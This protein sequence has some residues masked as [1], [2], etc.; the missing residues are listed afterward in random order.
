MSVLVN[1]ALGL[2]FGLGLVLS[3]MSDPAK[4][5]N[6]LDL[7]GSFDPSLAFVMGGAVLVA[8][9]GY[10]LTLTRERPLLAPR[11]QLPTR[12]D[13]DA[14]LIIGPALF[15]IG[16]GLGGFCPG[17]AFTALGLGEAGTLVFVPAMLAGMWAARALAERRG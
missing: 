14:R 15:G 2:L 12:R 11:F 5:L 8:F 6:F 13:I 7:A 16:W 3:G 17:P 1:L 9:L 4:V 10:R